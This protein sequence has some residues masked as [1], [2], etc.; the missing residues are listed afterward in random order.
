MSGEGLYAKRDI[1]NE[2]LVALY[3]GL[4]FTNEEYNSFHEDVCEKVENTVA[5]CSKYSISTHRVSLF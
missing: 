2:E 1:A 3:T 5:Y 4:T